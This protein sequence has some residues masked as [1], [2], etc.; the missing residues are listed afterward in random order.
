MFTA[1]QNPDVDKDLEM[2]AVDAMNIAKKNALPPILP[3]LLPD[4]LRLPCLASNLGA[5]GQTDVYQRLGGIRSDPVTLSLPTMSALDRLN[6]AK[7]IAK[8]NALNHGMNTREGWGPKLRL[9]RL[10]RRKK[11]ENLSN[12][13][14][15]L[16]VEEFK[17]LKIV[18]LCNYFRK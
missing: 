1:V 6:Q 3:P 7:S 17:N 18:I 11:N 10:P 16:E 9:M 13:Y 14:K 2:D 5:V 12:V 4:L 8:K 15:S